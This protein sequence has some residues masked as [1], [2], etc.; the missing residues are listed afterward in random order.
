MAMVQGDVPKPNIEENC[1]GG[2]VYNFMVLSGMRV[3]FRHL[4]L[5]NLYSQIQKALSYLFVSHTM[6]QF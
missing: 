4:T 3:A 6:Q 5:P 2:Q 1:L